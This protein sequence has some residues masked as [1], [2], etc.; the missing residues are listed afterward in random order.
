MSWL[1]APLAWARDFL[2]WAGLCGR[3]GRLLLVGLDNAGKTSLMRRITTSHMV[4]PAPTLH[5]SSEEVTVQSV[6]FS[7]HDLGGHAQARRVWR[8]YTAGITGVVFVVD[9][10]DAGRL[11]ESCAELASLLGD[12]QLSGTPF[13]VLGNKID[14]A[15]ACSKDELWAGLRLPEGRALALYMCSVLNN[16][17]YREGWRAGNDPWIALTSF[18]HRVSVDGRPAQS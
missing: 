12:D 7:I 2:E 10:A 14:V 11:D 3:Q 5:A 17:G 16:T 8:N 15:G 1:F 6:T 9:A 18:L 4:A 13:L